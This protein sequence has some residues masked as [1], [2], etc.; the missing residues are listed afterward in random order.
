HGGAVALF[1]AAQAPARVR[2]L[3][4]VSPVNP[5]SRLAR[6]RLAFFGTRMGAFLMRRCGGPLLSRTRGYFLRRMY[7]DPARV[8]RDAVA[9]YSAG[10]A[11][12]GTVPHLLRVVHCWRADVQELERAI[13][14]LTPIPTLLVW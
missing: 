7:G 4:L 13:T 12:P 2:R 11:V 9:G 10:L 1:A 5:W 8:T 3:V 6:R 14:A